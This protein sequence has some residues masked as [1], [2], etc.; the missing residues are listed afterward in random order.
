MRT[1]R[2]HSGGTRA[3]FTMVELLVVVLVLG[4]VSASVVPAIDALAGA[5]RAG[6]A[7]SIRSTLRFARAS[8]M[9]TGQPTGV[10]IDVDDST[11]T[12]V[13]IAPDQ[14]MPAAKPDALGGDFGPFNL[15]VEFAGVSID[16]LTRFDGS[17]GS[18]TLWFG[19][20]GLPERRDSAGSLLG[21]ATSN[22]VITLSSG[23][24]V[25]LDDG[26]GLEP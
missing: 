21:T 26:T 7:E 4:I 20:D 10:D 5:R 11:L 18:G 24:S 15:A 8:A 25:T 1:T 2:R 14:T 17:S 9:L 16:A 22:A 12:L 6:A 13:W 23:A 19:A 3:A